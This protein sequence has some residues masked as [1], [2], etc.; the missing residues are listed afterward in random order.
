MKNLK[1][2][3]KLALMGAVFVVPFAFVTYKMA[4]SVNAL[5]TEFA[6]QEIRGL[7]YY[8]PLLALLKDLQLHRGMAN[9]LFSGD[10]SFKDS[11]TAKRADIEN[12]IKKIDAV[13]QQLD[14]ALHTGQKWTALSAACRSLLDKTAS[15]SADESFQQH[16]KVIAD[17][18]ALIG[19]V[20]DASNLTLDPDIDS[21]YLMNVLI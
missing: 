9:A 21:Y 10:I 15:L 3:Q 5:G 6:R 8:T 7:E 14:S 4:S 2:W 11:A 1:V 19:D 18:I 16:T 17:T 12:D 20:G 13:N